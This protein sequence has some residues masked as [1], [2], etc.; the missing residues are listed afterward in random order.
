MAMAG[1]KKEQA[2]LCRR[3]S[4]S[5]HVLCKPLL[6]VMCANIPLAKAQ[7]MTI[8][9]TKCKELTKV[10]EER[11]PLMRAR[12]HQGHVYTGLALGVHCAIVNRLLELE[13]QWRKQAKNLKNKNI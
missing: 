9:E 3:A 10:Q 13:V 6:A 12:C 8:P 7:H 5:A 2:Q 1:P 4:G 11:R